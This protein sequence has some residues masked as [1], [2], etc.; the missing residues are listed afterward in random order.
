MEFKKLFET[1]EIG[2]FTL[3]NRIIVSP[4]ASAQ[5]LGSG[6][7]TP[8]MLYRYEE[9]ARGGPAMIIVEIAEVDSRHLYERP[10]LR[11][12]KDYFVFVLHELAQRIRL[13]G[14][15]ACLQLHHPGIFG[16]DPVSP[17]GLPFCFADDRKLK[18]R[19]MTSEE[20]KD[21]VECFSN[22][23]VRAQ[24]AGFDMVEVHGA[25]S[26]LVQQFVSPHSNRRTD[27]W[28]GS[29]DNRIR[30]PLEIVRQIRKKCGTDFPIGYRVIIDE[31]LPDGTTL[32]ESK[33]FL[34]KME[35][36]G[37][38]Y[39]NPMIGTWETQHV[40]EGN[41]GLR[42]PKGDIARYTK[43]LKEQSAIPVLAN[44]QIH[45]PELM[46]KIL[47]NNQADAISLARP[48]LADPELPNKIRAGRVED[49]CMC[50]RCNHCFKTIYM[51]PQRL[52]CLQN[53]AS[54]KGNAFA[55]VPT[56]SSK[57]V[58]V[59]GGGPAGLEAAKIAA[60][61]GHKVTLLEREDKLGGQV[62]IAS[63]SLGREH[64]QPYIIDFRRGQCEKAGVVIEVGRDVNEEV[65]ETYRPDVVI[66]ATGASPVIPPNWA[67]VGKKVVAAW[68]VLMEEVAVAKKVV[69]IGGGTVGVETAYFLAARKLSEHITIIEMT[70]RIGKDMHPR[71]QLY[72]WQKFGK[73]GVS[74]LANTKVL[75]ITER[76]IY[77]IDRAW[78]QQMIEADTIVVA[79]GATPDNKLVKSLEGRISEVYCIGD[80]KKPRNLGEAILE[81]AYVARRI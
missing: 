22:A 36:E 16:N 47:E 55:V 51:T 50:I 73:Y 31:W 18:S 44:G 38:A 34:K 76:G 77:A 45:E 54:G 15:L 19:A 25:S 80:C 10:V 62:R 20:V 57:K 13:N 14:A 75:E 23:A 24:Q 79:V 37:I 43:A 1:L 2:S 6:E 8:E 74:I 5:T 12:D 40:G 4:F 29:L 49:I 27:E 30:L 72:L 81:G 64:F 58:L 32:E 26:Y 63:R 46:E 48:F 21:V 71:D 56:M 33:V 59:V 42:S 11:I 65:V 28:G 67:A 35:V 69:I 60:L 70:Q 68:D 53:P 7:P 78:R 3:K 39:I 41:F 61:R 66:L 9:M 17:S 52:N